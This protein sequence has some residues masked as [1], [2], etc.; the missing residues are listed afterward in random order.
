M[1]Y[2]FASE[3]DAS[4]PA[5]AKGAIFPCGYIVRY[6][7]PEEDKLGG[8]HGEFGLALEP[9]DRKRVWHL[10]FDSNEARAEWKMVL[11]HAALKCQAPLFPNRIAA[12]AFAD[13]YRRARR[14]LGLS[15]FYRL[16]RPAKDQL[17]VLVAQACETN[18]LAFLYNSIVAATVPG[19]SDSASTIGSAT[20]PVGGA[21]AMGGPSSASMGGGSASGAA[22]GGGAIGGVPSIAGG[23]MITAAEADKMRAG[24]DRELDRIVN[25]LVD[26]A[27]PAIVARLELRMDTVQALVKEQGAAIAREEAKQRDAVR[28]RVS[29]HLRPVAKDCAAAVVPAILSALLKPLYKAHKMAIKIFWSR[30][31]DIVEMGLQEDHLRQFYRDVRWQQNSLLPAFRKIRAITRG[32]VGDVDTGDAALKLLSDLTVPLPELVALM[33]GVSFYEVETL[34]EDHIRQLVGWAIYSFVAAVEVARGGVSPIDCLHAT[35]RHLLHDSKLRQRSNLVTIFKQILAPEVRAKGL[36]IGAV[37]EVAD[38]SVAFNAGFAVIP[39]TEAAAVAAGG[40]ASSAA[41]SSSS[42]S[43]PSAAPVAKGKKA[44]AAVEAELRSSPLSQIFVDSDWILDEVIDEALDATIGAMTDKQVAGMLARLDKLPGK[45]GFS[46][47]APMA[48]TGMAGAS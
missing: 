41:S 24:I 21:G 19:A 40:G 2:Y 28:E 15:G 46:A 17:A 47:L 12:D 23:A 11:E 36:A 38:T 8:D 16:D 48:G 29:K 39:Y 45:L 7:T 42:S 18:V 44:A 20:S 32:E 6:T 26:S 43:L 9:L 35:M 31:H 37:K 1:I 34:F 13:A 3:K 14:Q 27:W 33:Q 5:K 25:A 30:V 10:R 22:A 4:N